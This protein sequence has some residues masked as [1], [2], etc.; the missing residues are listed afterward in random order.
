MDSRQDDLLNADV[1][2]INVG[3]EL[4][5][6]A[7]AEQSVAVAQVNWKPPVELEP[8]L[9]RILDDLL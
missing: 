2:V 5:A 3:L 8:D 6:E 7:L 4:F 1:M 9:E